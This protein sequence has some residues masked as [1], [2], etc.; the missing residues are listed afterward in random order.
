MK[1][2]NI[3]ILIGCFLQLC[4]R[5]E[6]KSESNSSPSPIAI[7]K[8]DSLISYSNPILISGSSFGHFFQALY[9][10]NQFDKMVDF[11]SN[12]TKE[13]FGSEKLKQF[14]SDKF[15]FD[16]T[17]GALSNICHKDNTIKLTYSKSKQFATRRK[18][19]MTCVIEN[20]SVKLLLDELV[21]NPFH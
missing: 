2:I 18:V 20:D 12:M 5:R 13:K 6:V 7:T 19:T 4:C 16:F 9:R 11:T 3:V 21:A 17:L 1:S 8:H 10:N 15:K 14:Y